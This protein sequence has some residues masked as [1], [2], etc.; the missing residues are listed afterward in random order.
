MERAEPV[1]IFLQI[2]VEGEDEL[3]AGVSEAGQDG[4]VLTEVASE[5]D[6]PYTRVLL[7]ELQGDVQ[8]LVGRGVVDQDDLELIGDSL[9]RRTATLVKVPQVRCAVVERGDDGEL[10]RVDPLNM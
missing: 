4:L 3:T 5:V 2:A 6:D 1:G 7:V 9:G 10:H 8:R